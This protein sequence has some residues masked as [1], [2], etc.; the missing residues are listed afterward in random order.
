MSFVHSV[1]A[2][3]LVAG[4]RIQQ[5]EERDED[6]DMTRVAF[7]G[8][9]ICTLCSLEILVSIRSIRWIMEVCAADLLAHWKCG[10]YR[11]CLQRCI[12][13]S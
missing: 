12:Q 7:D 2:V 9:E 10:Q 11:K 6:R 3:P 4:N 1:G 13:D 5:L 8:F